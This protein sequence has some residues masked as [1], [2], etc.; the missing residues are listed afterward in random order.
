MFNDGFCFD[1]KFYVEH[2]VIFSVRGSLTKVELEIRKIFEALRKSN[3]DFEE[4]IF[5]SVLNVSETKSNKILEALVVVATDIAVGMDFCGRMDCKNLDSFDFGKVISCVSLSD[6]RSV[7]N[8]REMLLST[9]ERYKIPVSGNVW[10]KGSLECF[11]GY[12]TK[13]MQMFVQRMQNVF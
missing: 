9:V 11:L 13:K 6:D 2:G 10:Y 12:Q 7:E 8:A 5:I 3:V 1:R 4:D